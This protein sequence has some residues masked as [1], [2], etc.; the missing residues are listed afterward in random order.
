MGTDPAA[1][2]AAE[3]N[4]AVI[5]AA[6]GTSVTSKAAPRT[7]VQLLPTVNRLGAGGAGYGLAG[8]LGLDPS[9]G[10][11]AGALAGPSIA[12][13]TER[14]MTSPTMTNFLLSGAYQPGAG[15]LAPMLNR[16]TTNR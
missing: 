16:A 15:L 9:M 6:R 1:L 7:G 13:G 4:Q 14:L 11:L 2:Q 10:A 12:S 3:T 8:L 5:D